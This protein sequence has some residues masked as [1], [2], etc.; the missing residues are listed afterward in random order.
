M[1]EEISLA[2]GVAFVVIAWGG[3][4]ALRSKARQREAGLVQK[5]AAAR[6][7]LN[8][9][10][11]AVEELAQCLQEPLR[12]MRSLLEGVDLS[13]AGAAANK[14]MGELVDNVDAISEKISN[15]RDLARL[16]SGNHPVVISSVDAGLLL[17]ECERTFRV[18]VAHTGLDLVVSPASAWVLTDP[19]LLRRMLENLMRNAIRFT[20]TGAVAISCKVHDDTVEIVVR[21]TGIGMHPHEVERI[22]DCRKGDLRHGSGRQQGAGTG[23]AVVQRMADLLGHRLAIRST[24]GKGSDFSITLPRG[25]GPAGG[26]LEG[27]R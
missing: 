7:Q 12:A 18:A 6:K 11:A 10:E 24:R 9:S 1:K 4:Q 22:I 2:S 16:A 21:D 26:H 5:L 3:F 13:G 25:K 17:K 8:A 23:L 27:M 19:V 15:I 20:F 14:Q